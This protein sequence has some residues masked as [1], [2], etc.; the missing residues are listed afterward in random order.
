MNTSISTDDPGLMLTTLLSDYDVATEKYGFSE[1]DLKN[2]VSISFSKY[3]F[4]KKL[5]I[6]NNFL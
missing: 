6:R 4:L 1:E 2:L 3:I 5:E